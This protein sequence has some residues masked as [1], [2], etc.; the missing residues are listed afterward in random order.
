M[1]TLV[2]RSSKY[3]SKFITPRNLCIWD[4]RRRRHIKFKDIAI[5]FGITTERAR[6]IY[7]KMQRAYERGVFHYEDIDQN[8]V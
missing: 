8:T 4:I 5:Q 3:S 6:Q 2:I 1:K 7:E